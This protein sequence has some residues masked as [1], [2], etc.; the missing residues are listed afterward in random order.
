MTDWIHDLTSA[1]PGRVVT[2][3]DATAAF[4]HDHCLFAPAGV[5]GAVV[6][7]RD[8]ADVVTTLQ[9][10]HRHA[11]PVVPRGA[12]T[13]LAGAANAI[14]GG[15]VLSLASMD[16]IVDLDP[17]A[18][19]ARVQP[20]VLNGDLDRAA[21]AHGLRYAPDPGSRQIS[22]IGGNVATNA[23]GMCC[24]KYGVTADHVAALTAVLAD[25]TIVRTGRTTRKDVAGLDLT[26]LL[27]G[28]EGTLAVVVEV[29]VR[30]QPDPG[31]PA[32]VVASFATTGRAI[33]A[34]IALTSS[35]VPAAVELMDATTI[36]A[37]EKHARMGL[38]ASAGALLLAQFDGPSAATDSAI[39]TSVFSA[40]GAAEVFATSD[41]DEGEAFMAA[42]AL[43]YP[44]LEALGTVLLDD[45]A[46]PVPDLPA[47]LDAI[48]D[49]AVRHGVTI[50]TFGHAADGNLHPTIVF[51]AS[52]EAA[53]A[54][55]RAAFEDI[56][57]AGVDL[58]GTITGE[59][60]VGLLKREHLSRQLGPAELA[61]MA[62]VKSA[63]DPL[64]ILNPGRGL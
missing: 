3:P 7:A 39:C 11:V 6:R 14:D 10:A 2:D 12:G 24:A 44:A 5:P 19:I 33:E 52:D 25:G 22:T 32:T 46:V 63:F 1:L 35:T 4:R 41:P 48:E 64:G 56:I 38:D 21:R 59:H 61:L 42:R 27:V 23:G 8:V 50:G 49:A 20:G 43:A 62:R 47:L 54:A 18:R 26:R 55:A 28:S 40:T 58:G 37:V 51:D 30:L 36:A 15:I 13:G 31:P 16:A 29:T 60:G 9:I 45:V 57:S 53:R 17:A 34:V